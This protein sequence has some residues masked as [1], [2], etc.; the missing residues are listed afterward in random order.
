LAADLTFREQV[1][2]D[3]KHYFEELSTKKENKSKT[4]F[5]SYALGRDEWKL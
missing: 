4:G 5:K 1:E 3:V 2:I